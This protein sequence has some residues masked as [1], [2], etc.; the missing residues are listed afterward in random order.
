MEGEF[1][2]KQWQSGF[3]F[4]ELLSLIILS[5]SSDV[6]VSI[7]LLQRHAVD[8]S[9]IQTRCE[10]MIYNNESSCGPRTYSLLLN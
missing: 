6:M 7:Q 9:I 1:Q 10:M 5:T 2:R 3:R 4:V 8:R